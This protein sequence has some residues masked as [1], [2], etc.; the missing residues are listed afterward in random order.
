MASVYRKSYTKPLPAGAETFSRAGE[1]HAR[2]KDHA[3]K[4]RTARVFT[5]RNGAPRISVMA[6]T[7]T[8]KYRDGSRIVRETAT[9]CRSKDA[10][11]AVLKELVD[12]AEK[13]RA[14]ILTSEEDAIA[15]QQ[16]VRFNL[17]VDAYT[18]CLESRG[19]TAAHRTEQARY[20]RR[21]AE[22][23]GWGMLADVQR[24]HLE[25]WMVGQARRQMGARNQNAHRNAALAFCRWCVQTQR[26]LKSP[27][28]GVAKADEK[29][30][31]RRQRRAL[32]ADELG[33]LLDAARRR[34]LLDATTV[35]RGPRKGQ[36]VVRVSEHTRHTK[37]RLGRERAL[38]YKAL[39]LTGLRR[40][41]LA[42]LTVESLVLDTPVP[43]V[44]L[45][46]E[47]EKNR[48]GSEIPLRAD[49]AQDLGRWVADELE[50]HQ[51]RARAAG[52]PA[53]DR[54][55]ANT[56]LLTV[57]TGLVKILDRDL[58]LA[59]I[60][61]KDERGRTVDVHALRHTFATL[62]SKGGT[63]PRTAQ[64]ALRHGSIDLT[65]NVYTDPKLLDV[66]GALDSLPALP[67]SDQ[68]AD[69]A[70]RATGTAGGAAALAPTLAPDWRKRGQTP[71]SADMPTG[72]ERGPNSRGA[73]PRIP[74][75]A[76]ERGTPP[77]QRAGGKW[78]GRLDLNQRPPDPQSGALPNCAT[79]RRFGGGSL[80]PAAG[81]AVKWGERP[82]GPF[83]RAAG[84]ARR[85]A[86]RGSGD[87]STPVHLAASVPV[88]AW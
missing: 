18:D 41:E 48:Q 84:D 20:L 72:E 22:D 75:G 59:G 50:R 23:C 71:S 73:R 40:N 43:H 32:T 63:A 3:G 9:G 81:G 14:G 76:R 39:V 33:R 16:S 25:R 57:P 28:D 85:S 88:V 47:H 29:S 87:D 60:A 1:K 2:W 11:R 53:P 5:G 67:L 24:D 35:N 44:V 69:D 46:P 31:R 65:M 37:L 61:K 70:V 82:G 54:L 12:R 86:R 80:L 27:L 49:L 68:D 21:L 10:A 58:E 77:A 8:A 4:P 45:H 34:P 26:L 66:A 56:P 64:A 42:S 19:T 36:R 6:A 74:R 62:L 15:N 51:D 17:H 83:D 55:P 13:V 38:I 52:A 79:P 78:S 7:Y 30:D